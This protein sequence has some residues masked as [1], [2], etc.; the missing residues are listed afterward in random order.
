MLSYVLAIYTIW[1]AFSLQLKGTANLDANLSF[2]RQQQSV[3]LKDSQ[4]Q[5][6]C[7]RTVCIPY[8][9]TMVWCIQPRVELCP[10]IPSSY[11]ACSSLVLASQPRRM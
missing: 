1:K 3:I 8:S 11:T 5:C 7:D 4:M 9:I 6:V 10:V 2:K